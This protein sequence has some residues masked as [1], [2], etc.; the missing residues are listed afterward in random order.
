VALRVIRIDEVAV[1]FRPGPPRFYLYIPM[2]IK[3]ENL[4]NKEKE[5]V[6]ALEALRREFSHP[7]PAEYQELAKTADIA[8][9]ASSYAYS[10]HDIIENVGL[11]RQFENEGAPLQIKEADL[12]NMG[13]ILKEHLK[14]DT[15]VDLGSGTQVFVP[16]LARA[17]G[18]KRY[19]GVDIAAT[20]S[21]SADKNFEKAVIKDDMLLFAAKLPNDYGSF[22][23]AGAEDYGG[24]MTQE[25][26]GTKTGDAEV[27]LQP[28][29]YMGKLLKE[30]Y[31]A[32]RQGGLLILG[33]NN[34]FPSPETV[35]FK[36]IDI[37]NPNQESTD[38]FVYIKK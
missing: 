33:V 21:F 16:N 26:Y 10:V 8:P 20:E 1:R 4:P 32:T 34:T 12:T 36:R 5:P 19:I 30:I 11:F 37:K 31:R 22:F 17:I 27:E 24:E 3:R 13:R 14:G 25:I 18:V 7:V 2:S 6:P 29:S 23:V 9:T 35:G 38:T 28:S 15:L